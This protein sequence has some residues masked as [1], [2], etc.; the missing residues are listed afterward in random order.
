[1]V[2]IASSEFASRRPVLDAVLPLIMTHVP[3]PELSVAQF[4]LGV[5]RQSARLSAKRPWRIHAKTR[6]H[7]T[8]Q[9]C[10]G[11]LAAGGQCTAT[12][13]AQ[14]WICLDRRTRKGRERRRF[15]PGTD[16]QGLRNRAQSRVG[17]TICPRRC[18]KSPCAPCRTPR[19]Q[20]RCSCHGGHNN[21]PCGAPRDLNGADCLHIR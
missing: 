8:C 18:R 14:G 1:M 12:C 15:A 20:G 4:A 13:L 2:P 10:H 19:A 11:G 16:R 7:Y 17:R 5:V 3:S 21:Q 9:R 6:V